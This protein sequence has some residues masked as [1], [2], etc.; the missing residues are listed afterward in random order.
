MET[1]AAPKQGA[2]RLSDSALER[3][4]V[5]VLAA[6]AA[7]L[8]L[9][10][11]GGFNAPLVLGFAA[12]ATVAYAVR[13]PA[14]PGGLRWIHV[15]PVLLLALVLRVPA[16][17]Y[18]LGGQDQGVYTSMAADLVRTGDLAV[19][20]AELARLAAAGYRERYL[21]DNY[22]V[23]FLPGVYNDGAPM[24]RLQFQFYHLFP[25]WLALAGGVFG[26]AHGGL[27]LTF[28]ALVSV[29]FFQRLATQLSGSDR[30]GM[31]AGLLLALNPLHVLFSRFPVTEV[32][33]LAFSSAGFFFLARYVQA[34]VADRTARWLRLSVA[35]F[36]CLF[37]TRI[38]GFMYL[39]LVGLVSVTA[40]LLDADRL[41]ARAVG[42][43]A[44]ACVLAYAASVA[45]GLVWSRPYALDIYRA[46]FSLL[47]GPRWPQ[48]VALVV[49]VALAFWAWTWRGARSRP[50]RALAK[51]LAWAQPGLG[52]AMAAVI[53]LGAWKAWQLGFTGR[54]LADA[55]LS[56]FPGMAGQGWS[57][58]AHASLVVVA[59][60]LSPWLL[61]A[62]PAVSA[63]RLPA[64]G[65]MLAFFVSCFLAYAALLNWTVPYQPYYARYFCSEL[66]PYALLLCV[67]S[68]GWLRS[69]AARRW[70]AAGL[71]LAGAWFALVSVVQRDLR[72]NAGARA[73]IGQLAAVAGP[74]DVILLDR[75]HGPGYLP[76]EIKTTLVYAFGRHVVSV[77]D[78]ALN[79][80][81][82]LRVLSE[83]YGE[84]FLVSEG[85]VAPPGW[86][87]VKAVH[88]H[89][90][91][92]ARSALPPR[93]TAATLDAQLQVFRWQDRPR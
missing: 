37:L 13:A 40:F 3:L 80:A 57:S 17:D 39:P 60:H 54:Y 71:V 38:S 35:A 61:L 2:G 25:V 20:D 44:L 43:W 19:E 55:W 53:A 18:V 76:K 67:V 69:T 65:A 56:K 32:P 82:Y 34:P 31:A 59:E 36:L 26:L 58:V 42:G 93:E 8:L 74:D 41:R 68:L 62:L 52:L 73:S 30:I 47:A 75:F 12:L 50:L 72:E 14:S 29:L 49:V 7:G 63:R 87:H 89:A 90:T 77:G 45:Y 79:D 5:F 27:A 78:A 85:R 16:Y 86:T 81:G 11:T 88:L 1:R 83:G 28:L 33:T 24:P 4:L 64:A 91:G 48:V 84:V 21:A 22:T 51:V 10:W 15:A 23:P 92:M 46:S 66:V 70:L 9:G 6:S